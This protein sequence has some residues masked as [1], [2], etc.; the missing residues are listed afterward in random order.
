MVFLT[1]MHKTLKFTGIWP[2]DKKDKLYRLKMKAKFALMVYY[3]FGVVFNLV[4]SIRDEKT[5][6]RDVA[7]DLLVT[8]GY[9]NIIFIY[10]ALFYQQDDLISLFKHLEDFRQF[11][12]PKATKAISKLI[13]IFSLGLVWYGIF[14]ALSVCYYAAHDYENCIISTEIVQ[15]DAQCGFALR[16]YFPY[17]VRRGFN[18]YLHLFIEMYTV[19]MACA[20]A[21]HLV[22]CSVAAFEYLILR[23]EHLNDMLRQV[24]RDN[25]VDEHIARFRICAMYHIYII[26]LAQKTNDCFQFV[27]TPVLITYSICIGSSL[28]AFLVAPTLISFI[29]GMGWVVGL[30]LMCFSGQRIQNY[31][32]S[33]AEVAYGIEWGNSSTR[34][35]KDLMFM[36]LRAN[37]PIQ[38]V[39]GPLGDCNFETFY[40]IMSTAYKFTSLK[41]GLGN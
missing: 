29:H 36:L 13:N 11:G 1:T 26:D 32:T 9:L 28:L 21:M 35:Q 8:V 25:D 30:F 14:G 37:K 3:A 6:L 41:T 10:I 7:E 33:I 15:R 22:I 4:V 24:F 16:S 27:T 23:I 20:G 2:P 19:S 31:S 40:R 12:Y 34:V 5:P 17:N 38:F 18:Y 39:C